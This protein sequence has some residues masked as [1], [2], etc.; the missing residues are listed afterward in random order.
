MK[1]RGMMKW[2]PFDSIVST[3]KMVSA[4]V[5]EKSKI[6]KPIMS[7]DQ[8]WEMEQELLEGFHSKIPMHIVYYQKGRLQVKESCIVQICHSEKR[9]LFDD[10]SSLYFDQ[11]IHVSFLS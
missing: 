4:L 3:Q 9:I 2:M 6:P 7:E 1:D 8:I 11:I 5:Y 10:T